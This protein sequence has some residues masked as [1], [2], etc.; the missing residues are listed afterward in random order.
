MKA[1]VLILFAVA[2]CGCATQKQVLRTPAERVLAYNTCPEPGAA[3]QTQ[4]V[5]A[6]PVPSLVDPASAAE[7]QAFGPT[8]VIWVH[9][10]ERVLNRCR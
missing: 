2:L 5:P 3:A 10:P 1:S 4:A 8:Q 7:T 9:P 6:G